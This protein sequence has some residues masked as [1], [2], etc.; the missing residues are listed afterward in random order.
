MISKKQI[1]QG[2]MSG[3][4]QLAVNP[5]M[6]NG[7]VS[8]IGEHWFFF[9]GITAEGYS[10]VDAYKMDIPFDTIVDEIYDVLHEWQTGDQEEFRDEAAYYEAVLAEKLPKSQNR[11]V[12]AF[13]EHLRNNYSFDATT[14]R[15][16]ETI[17]RF[18]MRQERDDDEVRAAKTLLAPLNLEE[19]EFAFFGQ[20]E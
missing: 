12:M 13:M 10:N 20:E 2:L 4:I 18:A 17:T 11:Q 5:M 19:S 8:R 15:L 9:G 3:V 14:Q 1:A 16:V 6:K 7:I